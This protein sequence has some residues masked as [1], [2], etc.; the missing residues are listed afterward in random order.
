MAITK[1]ED[2][3]ARK[4]AKRAL[5]SGQRA[6]GVGKRKPRILKILWG[7]DRYEF[8]GPGCAPTPCKDE[9]G[10]PTGRIHYLLSC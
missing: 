5:R 1:L 7:K 9:Q 6:K 2:A 10:R 3:K 4:S 8:D